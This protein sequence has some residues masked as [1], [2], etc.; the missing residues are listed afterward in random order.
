M[1]TKTVKISAE[2]AAQENPI[3]F[4]VQEANCFK[5]KVYITCD[6][7]RVNAKSIMGMMTLGLHEGKEVIIW[8]EGED[9]EEAAQKVAIYLKRTSEDENK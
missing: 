9:E 2:T 1:I 8:A 6:G 4:L 5:S 7:K 3:A